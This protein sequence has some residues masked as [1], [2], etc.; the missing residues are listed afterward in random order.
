MALS[1]RTGS[2]EAS[3]RVRMSSCRL[4]KPK[5]I[6]FEGLLLLTLAFGYGWFLK[7]HFVPLPIGVDPNGYHVS[8]R[9]IS[10]HGRFY[11]EPEDPYQF[12]GRMW[13]VN[14]EG[15]FYAKY[16]PLYP[17]LCGVT[18][19]IFGHLAG[20]AVNPLCGILAVL[21]VYVL[22][23]A[24]LPPGWSLLAS[25][26]LAANPVFNTNVLNQ[27]SHASNICFLVW[28][29]AAVVWSTGDVLR[30]STRSVQRSTDRQ[31]GRA[32][33]GWIRWFLLVGGGFL[34][35][36]A[37]GIRYTSVLLAIP[38]LVLLVGRGRDALSR[39]GCYLAGV[40]VPWGLM[41][42][43][44]WLAF[45]APWVTG[46]RLTG[47]QMGFSWAKLTEHA[48]LYLTG[49]SGTGLGPA[50]G[51]GVLGLLLMVR[52][53][54][55]QGVFF[56]LWIVPLLLVC[57]AFYWAPEQRPER[58]LR[59]VLPAIVALSLL[60]AM[61][62]PEL[63]KVLRLGGGASA[64]LVVVFVAAQGAWAGFESAGTLDKRTQ[65]QRSIQEAVGGILETVP[66]GAVVIGPNELLNVLAFVGSYKLYPD[67]ILERRRLDELAKRTEREGPYFLQK[68]RAA[69]LR[70]LLVDIG[71]V[72][73]WNRIGGL[74]EGHLED[75]RQVY[76]LSQGTATSQ[77]RRELGQAVE[78]RT[79]AEIQLGSLAEAPPGSRRLLL[80]EIITA[81]RHTSLIGL[82]K[83]KAHQATPLAFPRPMGPT[84][85]RLARFE[86]PAHRRWRPT[87]APRVAGGE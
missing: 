35:G 82:V 50:F 60:A 21:G 56:V 7:A 16:P 76:L 44:N 10:E 54:L 47:E 6:G 12:V 57:M 15:R 39:T 17:A 43:F 77:A 18:M 36:C 81:V 85:R 83:E 25:L 19:R 65:R 75:G 28:G 59:L 74:L 70:Q 37:G 72:T 26:L 46:Y 67:E 71:P 14:A 1:R 79:V 51:L 64:A 33:F 42:L 20:M 53:H 61:M 5:Q 4:M 69:D 78:L 31:P 29:Y 40:A 58:Y 32:G 62:L 80:I 63:A 27:A 48:G 34:I 49:L 24:W 23:R 2:E 41:G 38:P 11:L 52:R 55:R 86:K 13:V 22:S 8:A 45:G 30:S 84:A 9:Q 3:A 73:Y 66:P 68:K 87:L